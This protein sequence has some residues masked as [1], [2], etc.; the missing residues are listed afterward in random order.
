MKPEDS[1]KAVEELVA[2]AKEAMSKDSKRV[3]MGA[4]AW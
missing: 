1:K 4:S 2:K 3:V